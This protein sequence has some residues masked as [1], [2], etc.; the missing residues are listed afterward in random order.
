MIQAKVGWARMMKIS[1]TA[2]KLAIVSVVAL[3]LPGAVAVAQPLNSENSRGVRILEAEPEPAPA[4][5][6]VATPPAPPRVL[7][8]CDRPFDKPDLTLASASIDKD[9]AAGLKTRK[10]V[11]V[12]L[13]KPYKNDDAAPA[14]IAPWL[15]EVKAGGGQVTVKEYCEA[16]RGALGTWLAKLFSAKPAP[17]VEPL[18]RPARQYD[19]I[20]H[21]D[22]LD[23]V[24]TQVEFAPK[25]PR[26]GT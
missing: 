25:A 6:P 22:A 15:A 19:V 26:P 21:A 16:A 2:L 3:A 5:K 17:A 4:A 13:T 1:H 14:A 20:L 12:D 9:L 18:Y 11:V 10:R 8:F 7:K 24:I 23:K